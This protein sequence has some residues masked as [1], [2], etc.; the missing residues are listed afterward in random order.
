MNS[1]SIRSRPCRKNPLENESRDPVTAVTFL[2]ETWAEGIKGLLI[3]KIKVVGS[4]SYSEYQVDILSGI[5]I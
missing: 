3:E 5:M 4:D 2:I 1:L